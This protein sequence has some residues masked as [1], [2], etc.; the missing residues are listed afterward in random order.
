MAYEI[1]GHPNGCEWARRPLAFAAACSLAG[2]AGVVA[3]QLFGAGATA[4]GSSMAVGFL[5]LRALRIH[6]PPALAVGLI[7]LVMPNPTLAYP[8][9]VALGTLSLAAWSIARQRT[10]AHA[11]SP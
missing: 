7:P 5:V 4:A 1:F 3:I 10:S 9:S 2:L 8:C 6:L 11:A